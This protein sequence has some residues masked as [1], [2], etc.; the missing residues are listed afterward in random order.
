MLRLICV[1]K[2]NPGHFVHQCLVP[3]KKDLRL[4]LA[5]HGLSSLSSLNEAGIDVAVYG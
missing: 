4:N 2:K 5:S 3:E 1:L